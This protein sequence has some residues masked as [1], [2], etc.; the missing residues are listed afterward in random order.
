MRY[1]WYTILMLSAIKELAWSKKAGWWAFL[2]SV[3]IISFT[4]VLARITLEIS[5]SV[6]DNPDLAVVVLMEEVD[7]VQHSTLLREEGNERHY[8]VETS[9]GNWLVKLKKDEQW[10]ISSKENLRE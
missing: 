7:N 5:G 1:F 2:L 6:I 9:E 3:L 10:H 8:L 4:G